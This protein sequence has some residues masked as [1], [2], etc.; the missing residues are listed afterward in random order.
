LRGQAQGN[1][2]VGHH[3]KQLAEEGRLGL[4]TNSRA[5]KTSMSHALRLLLLI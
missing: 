3:L 4:Q 2:V 1:L 5:F